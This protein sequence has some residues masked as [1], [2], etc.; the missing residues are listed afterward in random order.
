VTRQ[1]SDC[2]LP[3]RFAAGVLSL[4]LAAAMGAVGL[5]AAHADGA[6]ASS[7]T[8]SGHGEFASLHVTVAKTKGLQN[9][10]VPVTWTG[11]APTSG[12]FTIN[13]LQI[14][15]CW[16]DDPAGP[17]R[18]QCQYGGLTGDTRGGAQ[19]ASRQVTYNITDPAETYRPQSPGQLRYV[20]F[21]S[22]TGKTRESGLSEFF[23][24]NTTNEVPFGQTRQDG[25]GFVPF[26]MQTGAEAPGLGCG[27]PRS[28]TATA[29]IGGRSC[30]LVIVPRGNKEVDGSFRTDDSSNQLLSSPLSQSN[31]DQRLVV[32]LQFRPVGEPCPLG[33]AERPLVGDENAV[34]AVSSYQ[35]VLC[36]GSGPI[37]SLSQVPDALARRQIVGDAP[38]LSLT[39][40]PLA[41]GQVPPGR[42]LLYAPLLVNALTFAFDIESQAS[43]QAPDDVKARNGQRIQDLELTPRLIAKLLTQSYQLGAAKDRAG[44]QKN[45]LDLT[46]DK[47]FLALNPAFAQLRFAGISDITVPSGLS[48]AAGLV[49]QWLLSDVDA[50]AFLAGKPD[51]Y[52]AVV[53]PAYKG[54]TAQDGFPKADTVCQS[55]PSANNQPPLCTLDAH[56]YAA[57]GHDAAR[58]AAR[59]DTLA[60][61]FYDQT[62]QPPSYKKQAPQ[63]SGSRAVIALADA[64]TANRYGLQTARLRNASGAFVAP[65]T[66]ALLAGVAAMTPDATSPVLLPNPATTSSASYPLTQLTYAIASTA[67]LPPGAG[68]DYAQFLRYVVGNGQVSGIDPGNLPLGYAPLPPVLRARTLAAARVLAA[69]TG[70]ALGT[71]STETVPGSAAGLAAPVP[72]PPTGRVPQ[73]P[74]PRQ[75]LAQVLGVAPTQPR[76]APAPPAALAVAYG[77]QTPALDPGLGRY[78]VLICLA[79]GALAALASVGLRRITSR[80]RSGAAT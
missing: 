4:L 8:V 70:P 24:Q 50:R 22:V 21:Q 74:V 28:D 65:T 77:D 54:L 62:A 10:V 13:Y 58:G 60:R 44:L 11:A 34:E 39:S 38:S 46:R 42:A 80:L 27:D 56:P 66:A 57:D 29:T 35:P 45:P 33:K 69:G 17:S 72:L 40:R 37:F 68:K 5:G 55:F 23:D 63:P 79:L 41:A 32:P 9:E 52:G 1:R 73:T 12:N 6:S 76:I 14:M 48:D 47:E 18:E 31:W 71:G 67:G 49:W 25:K 15:Q 51:P 61:S 43:F 3:R 7:V 78:A 19:V 59:G 16:G 36:A 26:E 64:A 75:G 30:W 53:N 20:P 2:R